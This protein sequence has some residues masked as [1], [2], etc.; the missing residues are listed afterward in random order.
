VWKTTRR[1]TTHNRFFPT[2]ETRDATF[3]EF[4]R[5]PSLVAG[6]VARFR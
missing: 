2:V 5:R 4:R 1:D 3:A 6:H